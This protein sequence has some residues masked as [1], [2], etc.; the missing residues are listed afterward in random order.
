[1]NDTE[2]NE[3]I[4]IGKNVKALREHFEWTQEK[5]AEKS[6]VSVRIIKNIE[7]GRNNNID[8]LKKVVGTGLRNTIDAVM[9]RKFYND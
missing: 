3:L 7:E 5:L 2:D 8:N 1:M 6:G 9:K 4:I